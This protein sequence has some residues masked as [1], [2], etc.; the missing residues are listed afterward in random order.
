MYGLAD[1]DQGSF[2]SGAVWREAFLFTI[3]D[4]LSDEAA[5]PLQ[6]GGATVFNALY[7]YGIKPTETVGVMG[8]GG[9]GACSLFM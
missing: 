2:A 6:C 3:P 5:A 1:L 8:V 9:L 7:T 4:G